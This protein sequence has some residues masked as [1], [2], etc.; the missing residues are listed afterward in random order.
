MNTAQG[1]FSALVGQLGAIG[2]PRGIAPESGLGS[3][4]VWPHL[5]IV[6]RHVSLKTHMHG[7][8][9]KRLNPTGLSLMIK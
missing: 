3:N 8:N 9:R 7:I 2:A 5:L 1:E 4:P 6:V